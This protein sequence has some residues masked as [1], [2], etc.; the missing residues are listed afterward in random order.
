MRPSACTYNDAVAYDMLRVRSISL[1][2]IE[3]NLK[4]D[5]SIRVVKKETKDQTKTL[6]SEMSSQ[7]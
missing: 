5:P 4:K 2:G 1:E 7:A 3:A 6:A